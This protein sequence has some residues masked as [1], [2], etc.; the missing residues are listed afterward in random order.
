[1]TEVVGPGTGVLVDPGDV[2]ALAAAI[3]VA[4]ELPRARV[5]EHAVRHCSLERMVDAY[6]ELY[7]EL[8]M[9]RAA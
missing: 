4:A 9:A 1:M 8:A 7:G 6:T 3:A 2:D 5:R